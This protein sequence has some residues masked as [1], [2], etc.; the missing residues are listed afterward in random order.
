VGPTCKN[1]PAVGGAGQ[2]VRLE[3]GAGMFI[4]PSVIPAFLV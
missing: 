2:S 3:R 1:S 4:N